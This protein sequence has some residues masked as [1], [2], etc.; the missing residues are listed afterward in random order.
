MKG[1]LMAG[2][3]AVERAELKVEMTADKKAVSLV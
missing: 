1:S 2:Y 3:S